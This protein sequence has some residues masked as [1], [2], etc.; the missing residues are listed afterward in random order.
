MPLKDGRKDV[1]SLPC[2]SENLQHQ[3][4]VS[5]HCITNGAAPVGGCDSRGG[6]FESRLSA[7]IDIWNTALAARPHNTAYDVPCCWLQELFTNTD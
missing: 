1:R 3:T 7:A 4:C 5:F 6:G 2:H